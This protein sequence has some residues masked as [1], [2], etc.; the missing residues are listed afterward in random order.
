MHMNDTVTFIVKIFIL[1]AILSIVI[2]YGGRLL[3]LN[4]TVIIAITVI[5]L[6]SIIVALVLSWRSRQQLSNK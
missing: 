1:S 4:P 6:P 2:K 3:S 5:L